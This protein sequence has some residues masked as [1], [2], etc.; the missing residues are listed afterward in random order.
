MQR[1][2]LTFPDVITEV[3]KRRADFESQ[4]MS[5][6]QSRSVSVWHILSSK[7]GHQALLNA[8]VFQSMHERR[9]FKMHWKCNSR[10]NGSA[11][12][13]YPTPYSTFEES[14]YLAVQFE[15]G[16]TPSQQRWGNTRYRILLP[17]MTCGDPRFPELA[18][19]KEEQL[20]I[21]AI[22]E[23]YTQVL[24]PKLPPALY[25]ENTLWREA[26][27]VARQILE[28]DLK[29]EKFNDWS[30]MHPDYLNAMTDR[31][32]LT[33][34]S[35]ER[36]SGR[37]PRSFPL[38]N[39][40]T[41]PKDGHNLANPVV[42]PKASSKVHANVPNKLI[43]MYSSSS[44]H[45]STSDLIYKAE[46]RLFSFF[47]LC[48]VN[49]HPERGHEA[50]NHCLQRVWRIVSSKAG[51]DALLRSGMLQAIAA[52]RLELKILAKTPLC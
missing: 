2:S 28:S 20:L 40:A 50:P 36:Q 33:S 10:Q 13:Y 47:F 34:E 27:G 52:G 25:N 8:K 14:Q 42:G 19:Y 22:V 45:L 18:S 31:Q 32:S 3:L 9:P 51:V 11:T 37:V 38:V 49:T 21:A 1:A 24:P 46:R 43:D 41:V 5:E 23:Y 15:Y 16:L 35:S 17:A 6:N 7:R 29:N 48:C 26:S 4:H 39:K 12:V 30:E 44:M